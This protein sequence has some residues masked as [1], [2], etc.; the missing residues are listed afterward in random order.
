MSYFFVAD[1][2]YGHAKIIEYCARPF[3]D[4]EH[5]NTVMIERHNAVVH[6]D[7]VVV[8]VGDFCWA[9]SQEAASLYIRQLNGSHI[10]VKGSHDSWLPA[11]AKYMWRSMIDGQFVVACHYAMRTWERAHHGSWQVYGHSH[12]TLPPIGKQYDCGVDCNDFTPVSFERLRSIM[13]EMEM[14]P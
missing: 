12:G 9:R 14:T 2:H 13:E 1:E 11:S 4:V 10:F 8:H 7:D 6:S 5:M 3:V